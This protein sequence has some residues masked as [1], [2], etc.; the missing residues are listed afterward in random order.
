MV[1]QEKYIQSLRS[2]CAS[3]WI[4]ANS[5][6]G[7]KHAMTVSS[8][9]P[10][11]VDPP[12]LLCCINSQASLCASISKTNSTFSANLLN[13]NQSELALLCSD[14]EEG[15]ARFDHAEWSSHSLAD[16]TNV[17][18]VMN[19]QFTYICKTVQHER[20]F[21]HNV[22]YASVEELISETMV[23]LPSPMV[24]CD[25]QFGKFTAR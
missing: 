25:R 11:S 22:V 17:P 21:T 1:S 24:Y 18:V 15:E 13:V 16:G 20:L 8:L 14:K 12:S 10:V 5:N 2:V 9:T 3:V 4:L 7:E 6:N 23:A 19:T